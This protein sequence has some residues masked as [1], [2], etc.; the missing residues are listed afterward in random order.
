[1]E[2]DTPP[3]K[4]NPLA[5]PD[6]KTRHV[7]PLG[8]RVLVRLVASED[9][10]SGGLFLPPGAK[11]AV[12]KAAYGKVVEVARAES[13]DDASFGANVSGIPEGAYVLFPKEAGLPIPWDDSLRVVDVKQISAIVE[14]IDREETH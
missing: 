13:E 8:P 10:S 6:N 5:P 7:M 11:D 9:R 12:A 4:P 3:S 2:D 14:E 1:M